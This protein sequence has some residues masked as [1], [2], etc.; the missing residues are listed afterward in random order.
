M[1]AV[2]ENAVENG[3]L[4]REGI[5][6]ASKDVGTVSFEGLTDDYQ[7]GEAADRNPPRKSTIFEVDPKKPFG[8][9]TKEY[10]YES[11]FAKEFEF[12]KAEL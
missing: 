7:Y 5:L 11:E 10:Q 6:K 12:K 4:S 3:D 9:G 2:L 8:L 1:S